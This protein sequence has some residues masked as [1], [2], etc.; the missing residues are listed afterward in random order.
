MSLS[1]VKFTRNANERIFGEESKAGLDS[2]DEMTR[3]IEIF[4]TNIDKTV[5]DIAK[6]NDSK[7]RREDRS[8]R[9]FALG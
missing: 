7:K 1:V 8:S 4:L 9:L 2:V 5:L 3:G 6:G